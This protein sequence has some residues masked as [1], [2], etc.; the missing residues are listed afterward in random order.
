[1]LIGIGVLFV[2]LDKLLVIVTLG[3][4][5]SYV[6][7]NLVAAIFEFPV[8]SIAIPDEISTVTLPLDVGI[9]LALYEAPEPVKPDNVPLPT[10]TSPSINPV[11]VSEKVILIG[12]GESFVLLDEV[13]VIV[14]LGSVPSKVLVSL[15]AALFAFPAMS[16]AADDAIST[17]TQPSEVGIIFALYE[18]PDPVKPEIVPLPTVISPC[19]KPVTDS[20]KVIIM[21][22]GESFVL[23]DEVL[24]IVALGRLP[25][26][27]LV[28]LVA[29]LL[30]FPAE[31]KA[32]A[33]AIST[34]TLPSD[35]G[36]IFAV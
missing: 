1:M 32:T 2:L 23:L 3:G 11:T 8:T 21:G 29:A 18:D 19:I 7:V 30:E 33:D 28:S 16:T 6:L 15:A 4:V 34:V 35:V 17:V 20:V 12:M 36:I 25:S 27:V 10:V 22:M 13:L 24:V 9:M 31:S 26:K 14:T 5:L